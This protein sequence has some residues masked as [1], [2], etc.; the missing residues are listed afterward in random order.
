MVTNLYSMRKV[1]QLIH[2]RPIVTSSMR[3]LEKRRLSLRLEDKKLLMLL[4][5]KLPNRLSSV[6]RKSRSRDSKLRLRPKLESRPMLE[7]KNGKQ[8]AKKS[9]PR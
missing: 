3:L 1:T 4:A 5:L 6:P 8:H 7:P 2:P 9:S